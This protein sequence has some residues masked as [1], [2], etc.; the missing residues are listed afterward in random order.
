[1]NQRDL[2]PG[3]EILNGDVCSIYRNF[4]WNAILYAG[5][6][7]PNYDP[8][9]ATCP[10]YFARLVKTP[11]PSESTPQGAVKTGRLSSSKLNQANLQQLQ[12]SKEF[13][14]DDKFLRV[15]SETIQ[16]QEPETTYENI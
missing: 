8:H 3:E 7:V 13:I 1:M 14:T 15:K 6:K 10:L 16:G 11:P 4:W 12:K 5:Q 2:E 9:G